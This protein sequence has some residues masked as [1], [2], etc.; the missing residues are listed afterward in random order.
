MLREYSRPY[1][2]LGGKSSLEGEGFVGT[3]KSVESL[4][5][6]ER[7]ATWMY[8]LHVAISIFMICILGAIRSCGSCVCGVRF[9]MRKPSDGLA[10]IKR[11][12]SPLLFGSTFTLFG[13]FILTL[14]D[15]LGREFSCN[16]CL[17]C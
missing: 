9:L 13:S 7:D 14:C 4:L 1:S 3:S 8:G 6:K 11:C 2:P 17:C 15:N 12:D 16:F 5:G 10:L